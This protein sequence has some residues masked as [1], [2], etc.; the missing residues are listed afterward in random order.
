MARNGPNLRLSR[1]GFVRAAG[2][3]GRRRRSA[4]LGF[5]R[6]AGERRRRARSAARRRHPAR[7]GRRAVRRS[8]GRRSRLRR[9]ARRSRLRRFRRSG[10]AAARR[11]LFASI[12]RSP[13]FKRMYDAQARGSDPR[14]GD[15]LPG[16]FPFRRPGRARERLSGA[17][18][19]RKRLAQ[20]NSER[21]AAVGPLWPRARARDRRGGRRSSSAARRRR[22]DGRRP[23]ALPRATGRSRRARA[24][25]LCA[26]ATPSLAKGS[27]RALAAEKSR[28]RKFHLG[29]HEQFGGRRAGRTD[30]LSPPR[31]RRAFLPRPTDRR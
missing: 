4:A 10:R 27:A 31:A 7:R 15:R 22:S 13:A 5:S 8:A 14:R 9:A 30:A 6:C 18:A 2:A 21:V 26:N 12:L 17:W 16:S 25:S 1:R 19:H 24:R 23:A 20:S 28:F 29:A 11:L 3:L